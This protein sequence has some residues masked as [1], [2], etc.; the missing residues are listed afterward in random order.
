MRLPDWRVRLLLWSRQ[1][2]GCAFE[3][4]RSDCAIVCAEAYDA[5]TGGRLAAQY[6]GRYRTARGA[7]RFQRRHGVTL[8][9]GLEK[10]GV[11]RW[12]GVPVMG[13]LIL[14][15]HPDGPWVV[16]HVVLGPF[17]LTAAEAPGVYLG[18]T[19][20]AI[21]QPGAGVWRIA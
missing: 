12:Q 20:D 13:D 2:L 16:G 18:R 19:E 11:F 7:A 10:A 1:R 15:P 3:W 4:G 6:A 14:H 8:R 21:A 17:C 5:I 9:E